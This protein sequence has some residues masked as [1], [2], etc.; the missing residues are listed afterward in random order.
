VKTRHPCC[1]VKYK[2]AVDRAIVSALVPVP[3][4]ESSLFQELSGNTK[5]GDFSVYNQG[6]GREG[7]IPHA[8]LSA[9]VPAGR[10]D[11]HCANPGEISHQTH[12][13][14]VGLK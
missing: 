2:T 12:L 4:I 11:G 9:Q 14:T 7:D 1:R 13:F 6:P 8:S 3:V 5:D 10:L